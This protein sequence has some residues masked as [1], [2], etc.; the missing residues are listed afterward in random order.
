MA[1]LKIDGTWQCPR[2]KQLVPGHE[3][4]DDTIHLFSH[5]KPEIGQEKMKRCPGGGTNYYRLK[6]SFEL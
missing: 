2:C 6:P 3:N 5:Y 4:R 1:P